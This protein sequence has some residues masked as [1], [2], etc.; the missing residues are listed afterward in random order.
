MSFS[1]TFVSP[2]KSSFDNLLVP[3][4]QLVRNEQNVASAPIETT[5]NENFTSLP[6]NRHRPIFH[7]NPLSLEQIDQLL[8]AEQSSIGVHQ[9]YSENLKSKL[10]NLHYTQTTLSALIVCLNAQNTI[11]PSDA[12]A[13]EIETAK[14]NL[15]KITESITDYEEKL[16]QITDLKLKHTETLELP[17]FGESTEYKNDDAVL[18]LPRFDNNLSATSLVEYYNKVKDFC[19]EHDL[20]EEKCKS[21]LRVNLLGEPYNVFKAKEK[22][23]L[24]H[25]LQALTDRFG[26]I[27]TLDDKIL[28]LEALKRATNES[29]AS[30]MQRVSILIDQTN[31]ICDPKDRD[32]RYKL[33]MMDYLIKM[34]SKKALNAIQDSRRKHNN[35]GYVF[36]YSQAFEIARHVEKSE[37]APWQ[38][39][40]A[41]VSNSLSLDNNSSNKSSRFRD[42][43]Y[44]Y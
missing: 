21:V 10:K 29:L 30:V 18:L 2:L 4:D 8:P 20:T 22:E 9:V 41:Y 7:C 36:G 31:L 44:E 39:C 33:K 32:T 43:I 1:P 3:R 27:Q 42:F 24:R 11:A 16:S 23:S 35:A 25:I 5:K 6:N 38:T 26:N 34:C 37:N 19:E 40:N 12:L 14:T 13:A 28:S 15:D 17:K